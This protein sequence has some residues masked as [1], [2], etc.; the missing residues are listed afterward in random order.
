MQLQQYETAQHHF[1]TYITEC[2]TSQYAIEAAYYAGICAT[3]LERAD[4][5]ERLQQFIKK[6]P[7]HQFTSLAY[8]ELGNLYGTRQDYLTCIKYYLIVDANQLDELLKAELQYRLAYAYLNE[9]NFDQALDYFNKIK[10]EKTPY[11]AASNYYAGYLSLKKGDYTSALRDL[12]QAEKNA[13]YESVVPYLILEV[14]YQS[15]KYKEAIAYANSIAHKYSDLKNQE[16]VALLI[17]ESYFLLQ[18]YT[19]AIQHYETYLSLQPTDILEEAQY[20][21][22]YALYQVGENY[23]AIK[24]FKELALREDHLAQ[25]A[26]YYMGV[27]YIKIDQKNL[28]LAA[29][30]QARQLDFDLGIQAEAAFQYAQLSYELGHLKLAIEALQEFKEA[31]PTSQHM[32]TVNNLLSQ[33]YLQ[34]QHYDLAIAHIEGLPEKSHTMLQVYQ[35]AT[36]YKGNA[37]FNQETYE[38]AIMWLQKSLR[39]PLDTEL[40]WQTHLWLAES[41]AAQQM[42]DQAIVHYQAVLAGENKKDRPYYQD[43]LYGMGYTYLHAGKY[44][45]A[46]PLFLQYA[47]VTKNANPWRADALVR[48]ADC[49]YVAKAYAQAVDLYNQTQFDYP[50]HTSYQKALIYEATNKTAEAKQ[51]LE[52]ILKK[53]TNTAYYEKA[54]FEYAYLT[55][56]QQDYQSAVSNFTQLIQQKPYS[57]LV[58]AALLHKAVAHVNLKQYAE[59]GKDYETLLT[60]YPTH[61]NTQNALIELPKLVDLEGKPEKLQHYLAIYQAKNPSSDKI[62]LIAFEAAKNLFYHQSYQQAIKQLAEFRSQYPATQLADEAAFLLA[63]AYYR[64]GDDSQALQQYQQ[65]AMNKQSEFYPKVLLRIGALSYKQQDF[66]TALNNYTELKDRAT[67][68]KESYYALEGMMKANQALERYEQVSEVA[69]LIIKLGNITVNAVSQ[70]TIYLAKAAMQQNKYAEALQQLQKLVVNGQD[71]YAAEAHYLMGKIYFQ[72][73]E[74]NQSLEA[75]F[76]LTKQFTDY[77]TWVNQG[78][79][80]MADDYLALQETFQAKATLQSIIDHAKDATLI[81]QAQEKLQALRQQQTETDNLIKDNKEQPVTDREF[82]TLEEAST[83]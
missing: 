3:K 68:K 61:P 82:K 53:Y 66:I 71:V 21:F 38:A 59:A 75:L 46:L 1:D 33:V 43:A 26:G 78:F 80:L 20:R 22:A 51:N 34:T 9:K 60:D 79:L 16:D 18:N 62:E 7:Y 50:A 40:T 83:N 31:Y 2:P 58:P 29:L 10:Q 63:E 36:F 28:A 73:G 35:K 81:E 25:L 13:A 67:N 14:L 77:P 12:Q 5:E 6:Y 48:A 27:A 17:A 8:Y 15:K 11:T 4:G 52:I 42:H 47:Q 19:A 23:K 72:L 64:L 70:A 57:P 69:H 24:H 74:Y 41:Y 45:Q 54:L 55:L 37:Y 32:K 56:Q 44:Q 30:N 65:A 76:T 49:Y 39:Y